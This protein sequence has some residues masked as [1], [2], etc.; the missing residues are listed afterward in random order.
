MK[1]HQHAIKAKSRG[2]VRAFVGHSV[3]LISRR[4]VAELKIDATQAE[5]IARDCAHDICAGHGGA[6]MYIPKDVEFELTKRDL[7]IF[8]R[9][10]G[11]NL[12]ELVEEYK[13]THTRIYQIVARVKAE[14]IRKRQSRLPGL[15]D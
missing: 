14:E 8:E 4:L 1:P 6:F 10:N 11:Q 2:R 3:E 13:V 5:E 7:E 12:H 15:D 9:F